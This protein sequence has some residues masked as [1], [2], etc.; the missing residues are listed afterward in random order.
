MSVRRR[1]VIGSV[2]ELFIVLSIIGGIL[3]AT[4]QSD[5]ADDQV[6]FSLQRLSDAQSVATNSGLELDK[7]D[8]LIIS[9]GR[10]FEAK[11]YNPLV[12]RS[13]AQ[14][15]TS[16]KG[17]IELSG[18]SELGRRQDAELRRVESL[19]KT[20]DKIA[21]TLEGAIAASRRG[22]YAGSV[23]LA[24]NADNA[25][26]ATFLPG[27]ESAIAIE[28]ANASSAEEQSRS[29]SRIARLVPIIG[30]PIGLLFAGIVVLLLMKDITQSLAA[31]EE[32]VRR[33][34]EGEL[35]IMIEAGRN[36][37]FKDVANAFNSMAARLKRT[38]DELRQY[39]HTVSHDLKGP[40][41]S[42]VLA[43][44]L[45]TDEIESAPPEVRERLKNLPELAR[46]IKENVGTCV[47]LVDDLLMLA[48]AGQV[49]TAVVP[50]NVCRTVSRI[51]EERAGEIAEAG[52]QMKVPDD[53][54][55]VRA[56]PAH[57]YQVFSN[58]ISNAL[59]YGRG[60]PPLI[61][62]SY[63][64]RDDAGRHSFRVRDNGPG[65]SDEDVEHIF[66]PFYKGEA[67]GTGIG[68]ATV[69]KIVGVY[70]GRISVRNEGGAVFDFTLDDS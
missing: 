24:A 54:G 1:L 26:R 56:S 59:K 21:A 50:V 38:T 51:L 62:V 32:G 34:G 68:L 2:I 64:G 30:A 18:D 36:D 65:V 33:L 63:L 10:S 46:I 67:G 44:G 60:E 66:E 14:W 16:L 57:V 11:D 28:E 58:L 45:I 5:R 49:P 70:G 27:L 25:Y 61:E 4:G 47:D 23:T 19:E 13:F 22:D 40:L 6:R 3:I 20:Y 42:V 37:E 15:T 48:E 69:A 53:L 39:D 31:L 9:G 8:D 7:A 29:A 12:D 17:N 43:G 41:T 55:T 52:A 35:D